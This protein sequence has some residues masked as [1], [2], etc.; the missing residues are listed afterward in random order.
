MPLSRL[1]IELTERC[2]FDCL[3]CAVRLDSPN[4]RSDSA[5]EMGAEFVKRILGEAAALGCLT[6]RLTGGDPLVR[7]DFPEIY[8]AARRLGMKVVLFT[9]AEAMTPEWAD[10]LSRVPPLE[11]VEITV[12]GMTE[13]AFQTV[14]RKPGSFARAR[15]GIDL[16]VEKRIPLAIKGVLFPFN[17]MEA[18]ALEAWVRTLP[19]SD[20]IVVWTSILELRHRRDSCSR[21]ET[22]RRLRLPPEE[23]AAFMARDKRKY[24]REIKEFLLRFAGPRGDEVFICGAGGE[25]GCVD[26]YG[27]FQACL[28]LR[29]PA[30]TVDLRKTSLAEGMAIVSQRISSLRSENPEFLRRCAH[31]PLRGLCE[32]CPAKAWMEEGRLDAPVE[33]YCRVAHAQA[34]G[35]GLLREGEDAWEVED[36]PARLASLGDANS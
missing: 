2:G 18:E 10:L 12:F 3:H 35:L 5:E 30:L 33:Y 32:Q 19:G 34:R 17:R 14:T 27:R 7:E 11:P 23:A 15:R 31:C 9:N 29:T 36:W 28:S 6:V 20:D 16:L 25:A 1:D 26:A 24:A 21:N 8:M 4:D 13:K 22:I